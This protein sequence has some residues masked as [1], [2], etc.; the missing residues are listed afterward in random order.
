MSP[1]TV[2]HVVEWLALPATADNPWQHLM[3][4]VTYMFTHIDF[5]H[6]LINC[7]WLAW[8]GNMLGEVAGK[9]WVVPVYV[10]G[11]IAGAIFY[12]AFSSVILRDSI[13]PGTMLLGASAATLALIAATIIITPGRRVTLAFIG[14]FPLK[15]IAAVAGVIF[16][17]AA[18]EMEPGQTAAHL[19][20]VAAGCLWGAGWQTVTRRKMQRM[21]KSARQRVGQ[22]ALLQKV[23]RNGYASLTRAEKL[24]LFNLSRHTPD[25]TSGS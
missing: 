3:S 18:F 1:E 14:T 16:I 6:L 11:G 21:K 8:F 20:G 25:S 10:C 24:T 12:L 23:R 7:L 19:G 17:L 13:T 4:P 9:R 15:W 2:P 5:W 22:A